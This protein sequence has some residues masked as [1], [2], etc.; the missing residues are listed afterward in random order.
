M[1]FAIDRNGNRVWAGVADDRETYYCPVCNGALI[2]K[3]KGQFRAE[4][5]AHKSGICEDSWHYDMSEW[6]REMQALF[7][8]K[9]REV[10]CTAGKEKHRADILK[11]GVVLELQ[12][13]PLSAQEYISRND[14]YKALGYKVVWVF[15]VSDQMSEGNLFFTDG[16]PWNLMI[17]KYPKQLL[18]LTPIV[19]DYCKD[20]ALFLWNDQDE[21]DGED[22][23]PI[24]KVIWAIKDEETD[25]YNFSRFMISKYSYSLRKGMDLNDLFLSKKD[26]LRQRLININAK[27]TLKKI[28]E[29]GHP[30]N[31]YV[32]PRRNSFGLSVY[33]ETGCSYCRY[34]GAI[35][36]TGKQN[37]RPTYNVYCCYPNK[38]NDVIEEHEGYESQAPVFD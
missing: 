2:I 35:E 1:E 7:D 17:W 15:D 32:C 16:D 38:V 24:N 5:F 34:C 30:Q 13:S 31:W 3:N 6:H 25:S 26:F 29:R 37:N 20:F 21:G 18:S 14:F 4:H 22:E 27:Y 11:D 36:E 10:V 23:I 33:R 8:E 12:H 19:S 9:Y 28:G